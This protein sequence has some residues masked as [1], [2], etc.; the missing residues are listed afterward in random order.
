VSVVRPLDDVPGIS[1]PVLLGE[2]GFGEVFMARK[3]Q[4]NR[5][6]AVKVLHVR[7]DEATMRRFDTE[8]AALGALSHHPNIVSVHRVGA[9]EAGF[10]YLIMEYASGG[11]LADA[12]KRDGVF[13]GVKRSRPASRSAMRSFCARSSHSAFAGGVSGSV[14]AARSSL[15]KRSSLALACVVVPCTR[16]APD[17]AR[18]KSARDR[19][20]SSRTGA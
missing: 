3:A 18:C 9:T 15:A 5:T 1:D 16:P 6:V 17:R 19:C 14:G 20:V 8:S 2:G 11:S 10:P 13:H 7:L 12:L 4:M